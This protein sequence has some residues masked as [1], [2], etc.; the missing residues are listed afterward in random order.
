ML[1]LLPCGTKWNPARLL[2]Q[3][4][5]DYLHSFCTFLCV[6]FIPVFFWS[7]YPSNFKSPLP[8][9]YCLFSMP[10]KKRMR[11]RRGR[12]SKRSTAAR[13]RQRQ[14]ARLSAAGVLHHLDQQLQDLFSHLSLSETESRLSSLLGSFDPNRAAAYANPYEA[15]DDTSLP[16]LHD[17][18]SGI[19][20]DDFDDS[21]CDSATPLHRAFCTTPSGSL[22]AFSSMLPPSTPVFNHTDIDSDDVSL[23][24]PLCY[25]LLMLHTSSSHHTTSATMNVPG[26]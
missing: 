15:D 8:Q 10:P 2:F 13:K 20:V 21:S 9:L 6:P 25:A 4:L 11:G 7:T 17:R 22:L 19:A 23:F 16:P 3:T 18:S 24:F 5:H 14:R 1:F 12:G 26:L